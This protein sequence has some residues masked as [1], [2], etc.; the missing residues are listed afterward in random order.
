MTANNEFRGNVGQVANGDASSTTSNG[1]VVTVNFNTQDEPKEIETVNGFQRKNMFARAE[2]LAALTNRQTVDIYNDFLRGYG[3]KKIKFLPV[4]KYKE[5]CEFLDIEIEKFN[6]K[7]KSDSKKIDE[8]MGV[9]D[10]KT[11]MSESNKSIPETNKIPDSVQTPS[12][13][14]V[15]QI[16]AVPQP[17][18]KC[19]QAQASLKKIKFTNRIFAA[20]L[21]ISVSGFSWALLTDRP[22]PEAKAIQGN[23][24]VCEHSGDRFSI[25]GKAKNPD[26]TLMQCVL[27][28]GNAVWQAVEQPKKTVTRPQVKRQPQSEFE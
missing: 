21:A 25:G 27:V 24:P 13:A 1:N 2:E 11:S 4:S 26:N 7:Q 18:K 12:Q 3:I 17:C 9:S 15:H 6:K 20:L 19:E 10:S 28:D 14:V 8:D 16:K 5:V 23:A 22:S